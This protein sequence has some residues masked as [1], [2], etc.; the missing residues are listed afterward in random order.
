M[1]RI[2]FSHTENISSGLGLRR[3]REV[4]RKTVAEDME[5]DSG[6]EE[7]VETRTTLI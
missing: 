2:Y 6:T 4:K 3:G 7:A 5:S 1:V